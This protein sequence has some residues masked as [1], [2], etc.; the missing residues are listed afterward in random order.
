MISAN[1][2]TGVA[3]G[4][5]LVASSTAGRAEKYADQTIEES[6]SA[7]VTV[8]FK[9]IVAFAVALESGNFATVYVY[10]QF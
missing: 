1:V 4:D 8:S 2:A 3:Q 10:S 6:G 9:P 5:R 7:T